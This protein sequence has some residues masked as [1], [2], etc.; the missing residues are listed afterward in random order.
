MNTKKWAENECRLA[1][2]K[3]NPKFDFDSNA[4]DYTC[5]CYQS[6]FKAYSALIESLNKD[7]HSGLSYEITRGVLLDLINDVPLTPITDNDF[8]IDDFWASP[9]YLKE[10]GLKAVYRC[11]RMSSL[12]KRETLDGK[13]FYSDCD[14]SYFVDVED[15]SDTF[16]SNDS[17]LNELF[18]ITMPYIPSKNKF[19]IY[20]QTFLVD[21]K[22]GDFDTRGILYVTTPEGKKV[23]LNIFQT[24]DENGQWV[25]ISKEEYD[26]LLE[27][28]IDKLDKKIAEK[29][30]WTLISNSSKEKEIQRREKWYSQISDE[31]K[32]QYL[33]KLKELCK[34][35]NNPDHYQYNTFSIRQAL[36]RYDL[37]NEHIKNVIELREIADY[38]KRILNNIIN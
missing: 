34:F 20:T 14:R 19:I 31:E 27:K 4:F 15:P 23:D 8:I 7:N 12:T 13:V 17:F 37:R 21:K 5:S 3:I 24:T 35:F 36:C 28:R 22:N 2:A 6:A 18:P 11:T 33:N 1:C 10:H 9:S 32:A 29:L 16:S 26:K 30:M 38:L 25:K